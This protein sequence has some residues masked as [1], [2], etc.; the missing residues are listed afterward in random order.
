MFVGDSW[1]KC[2]LRGDVMVREEEGSS[3]YSSIQPSGTDNVGHDWYTIL[4]RAA[5]SWKV[6]SSTC[7]I[8]SPSSSSTKN[9]FLILKL[10]LTSF[11]SSLVWWAPCWW[12]WACTFFFGAKART[13]CR[14]LTLSS[15]NNLSKPRNKNHKY[16]VYILLL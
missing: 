1:V 16:N 15:S 5:S 14:I 8:T 13:W 7:S 6:N 4:A 11:S 12:W 10:N 9:H 2:V 3:L